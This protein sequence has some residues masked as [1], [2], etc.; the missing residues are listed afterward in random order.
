MISRGDRQVAGRLMRREAARIALNG[1]PVKIALAD[2]V[3]WIGNQIRS[4]N[5]PLDSIGLDFSHLA[6]HVHQARRAVFGD[7]EA[8]KTWPAQ[9]CIRSSKKAT[10]RSGNR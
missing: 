6:E 9:C 3:V 5:L 7:D 1:T 4:Q 8:G 10:K 2:G